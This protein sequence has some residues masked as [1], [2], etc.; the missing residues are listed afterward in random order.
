[1]RNWMC[2]I[3]TG[4]AA[5]LATF[6]A[7]SAEAH[8]HVWITARAELVF[9]PDGRLLAIQHHWTFDQGYSAFSV[10]GLDTSGD[11][12]VSA[13]TLRGLAKENVES[14]AESS[15]LTFLKVDGAKQA[16]EPP[17]DYSMTYADRQTTLHYVLPLKQPIKIGRSMRLDV[18]DPTFFV[19]FEIARADDAVR[20][21]G[22][23]T[24]CS[25]DVRRPK[26]EPTT[27]AP[28]QLSESFFQALTAAQ[29]FGAKFSS[30]IQVTCP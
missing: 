9:A 7:P 21:I 26:A 2:R 14:L 22:A 4:V 23:P 11:G 10:Q 17:N 30:G 25:L 28:Q 6:S 5:A 16:F 19:D 18:Y 1:M 27:Q 3:L 20:L 29:G 13:E 12:Q 24:G 15:W 8:P